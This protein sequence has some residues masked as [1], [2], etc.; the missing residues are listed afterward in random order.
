MSE[1]F[2][3]KNTFHI[4]C[5]HDIPRYIGGKDSDGMRNLCV[6][7]HQDYDR[8]LLK[9]F[10][11]YVNENPDLYHWRD[12]MKWQVTIKKDL[13]KLHP[14]FRHITKNILKYYFNS[15]IKLNDFNQNI[16]PHCDNELD[17]EDFLIDNRCNVCFKSVRDEY[18]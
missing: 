15:D 14:I 12:V 2:L 10:L 18:E 4:Q 7:H 16:C 3:C 8:F 13:L 6:K 5:S 9:S 1:C 17:I 11:N